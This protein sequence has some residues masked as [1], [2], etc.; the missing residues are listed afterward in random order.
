LEKNEA[1]WKWGY[2]FRIVN[3]SFSQEDRQKILELLY[4]G[5]PANDML[6]FEIIRYSEDFS[7][8]KFSLMGLLFSKTMDYGFFCEEVS[9]Y[10]KPILGFNQLQFLK[11]YSIR[12]YDKTKGCNTYKFERLFTLSEISSILY[13][14]VKRGDISPEAYLVYPN[15]EHPKREE[16]VDLLI[17]RIKMRQIFLFY[18]QTKWIV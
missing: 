8:F 6:A 10:F 7:F 3:N 4:C 9:E 18:I 11:N 17:D 1:I 5:E 2:K 15:K 13:F 12:L 14:L 16:V